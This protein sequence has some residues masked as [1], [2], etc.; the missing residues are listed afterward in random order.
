[1]VQR[2]TGGD[3]DL[4]ARARRVFGPVLRNRRAGSRARLGGQ[5]PDFLAEYLI[6]LY[7]VS[8][9]SR[10]VE[11]HFPTTRNREGLKYQLLRE[12]TVDLLDYLE[13]SVDVESGVTTGH[14]AAFQQAFPMDAVILEEFPALLSGGL[15]G[16]VTVSRVHMYASPD[17]PVPPLNDEEPEAFVGEADGW[18]AEHPPTITAFQP[19]QA[20]VDVDRFI[21]AR[22]AFSVEEW[23]DLLLASAG[24]CPEWIRGEAEGKRLTRLYLLRLVPLV[25][26]NVNL[27]ELGP[28]NT[29][30]THLLRN[31]SPYAYTVAGGGATPA[32]LF[33]NLATGRAGLIQSRRVI[34][35][36]EISRLRFSQ[37]RA[38]LSLLKDYMES[39]QFSR[40]RASYGADTSLVFLGNLEVEG[41]HPAAR[42]RH[43]F[44][45]LPKELQD[46]AV[47]DRLHGFIPGWEFPK[48][49][50]AALQPEHALA[51]DY[52]GEVM[53]ALRDLPYDTVWDGVQQRWPFPGHLTRRDVAALDRLGRGL[54]KLVFPDGVV[55][56]RVAEEL[57]SIVAESR[58]RIHEQL[59]KMEPG[60]F[61]PYLVGYQGVP[62]KTDGRTRIETALDRQLNQRPR[63]GECTTV[64]GETD[65]VTGALSSEVAVA[66]VALAE[67]GTQKPGVFSD[68]G[69]RGAE[70]VFRV[71]QFFIGSHGHQL[72]IASLIRWE[73]M[74]VQWVGGPGDLK[75]NGELALV[76][77][78]V[79]AWLR[80]P[81]PK[82]LAVIGGLTLAGDVTTPTDIIALVMAALNR[83]RH[84]IVLPQGVPLDLLKETFNP[85]FGEVRW[86]PVATAFDALR[87]AFTR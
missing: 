17:P 45:V 65:S 68:D 73:G 34:I 6:G 71:A 18:M 56:E 40:G 14:L 31:L 61:A 28:K 48:L 21:E 77:A 44:E 27:V 53:L 33:V 1:M 57:L 15:W 36:D 11:Q 20:S 84:T 70:G 63:P 72:G 5:L 22:R 52:F 39:G 7:G 25:E 43:L 24:Y 83:G 9:A 62:V 50:P 79:S 8:Q 86:V 10:L 2:V 26:R 69:I 38:T 4:V 67:G 32:N 58:H 49:T 37:N 51:S 12:G 35:F 76:M 54:F 42:Y 75:G 82:A 87:W 59:M 78:L 81:L 55:D 85:T 30:K 66:Q 46:T 13:V 74:G 19:Y 41:R 29:G 47:L 3:D 60:E 23:I 64:V 80:K 16:R